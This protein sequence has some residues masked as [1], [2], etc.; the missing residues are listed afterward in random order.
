MEFSPRAQFKFKVQPSQRK[1]ISCHYIVSLCQ[2]QLCMIKKMRGKPAS[3]KTILF[4]C[5]ACF[6]AGTLFTGQ[7]WTS[8]S[9]NPESTVL[10]VRHDGGHK[11]VSTNKFAWILFKNRFVWILL[12]QYII[13][14][15]DSKFIIYVITINF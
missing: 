15:L 4:L 9:S 5:I 14:F 7:M 10:S 13:L 8:P 3:A 6:L 12:T 2:G 1:L 11:R